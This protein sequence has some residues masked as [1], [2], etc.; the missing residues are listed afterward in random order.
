MTQA[1]TTVEW[2]LEQ[3]PAGADVLIKDDRGQLVARG[4]VNPDRVSLKGPGGERIPI[5]SGRG[6]KVVVLRGGSGP[7]ARQDR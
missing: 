4:T 6:W 2:Q 3:L 1:H 5:M 7:H